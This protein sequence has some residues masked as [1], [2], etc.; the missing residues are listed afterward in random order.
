[1]RCPG[2]GAPSARETTI[3][4]GFPSPYQPDKGRSA[5]YRTDLGPDSCWYALCAAIVGNRGK[6]SGESRLRLAS[7]YIS[8]SFEFRVQAGT[9]ERP[10]HGYCLWGAVKLAERLGYECISVAEFGVAGGNTLRFILDYAKELERS[11]GI[12][13]EVYGFDTGEGL[14]DLEG[15]SDLPYWF[16]PRLDNAGHLRVA[17]EQVPDPSSRVLLTTGTD[18]FGQRRAALDWRLSPLDKKTIRTCGLVVGEYFAK[19]GLGRVRLYDWVL[20]DSADFP[21]FDDGEEVAGFHHM[22]TTRMGV[23]ASDGVVDGN[24]RVYGIHNLYV[25]GSSVFRTAGH[26]NPTLTIVQ[27]ALRLGDTMLAAL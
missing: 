3:G 2:Q 19:Q 14:P 22:G 20:S 17:S 23:T 7:R 1:M 13:I 10:A 21:G 16:Y 4:Q 8:L 15:P 9:L 27:L 12:K 25:V 26:A 24:C 18:Q 5:I 6:P 11:S